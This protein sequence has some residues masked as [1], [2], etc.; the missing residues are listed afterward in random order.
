MSMQDSINNSGWQTVDEIVVPAHAQEPL[1]P[2]GMTLQKT[3]NVAGWQS[4]QVFKRDS[5]ARVREDS[6]VRVMNDSLAREQSSYGIVL[7][8]PYSQKIANQSPVKDITG[9]Y[10]LSWVFVILAVLFCAVCMKFKNNPKYIKALISDIKD[11]RIR[12]NMFDN[13]V[14]ETTFL[15]LLNLTWIFCVGIL[16]WKTL[17][18][19][20]AGSPF[21]SF[22][23]PD[24]P[25]EGIGLCSGI[26]LVYL[27]FMYVSYWIVGNVFS[28]STNTRLWVKGAWASIGMQSFLLF[29]ISLLALCYEGDARILLIIAAGVFVLGKILFIY[30]GFRIFFNQI[31]SWLLFL[32]YLCSLDIVPF[33]VSYV[34]AII[35][36][37]DWL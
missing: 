4:G 15:M 16:L 29:P 9:G 22:G 25:L 3:T 35:V 18:L 5:L 36:C 32:Y 24:R 20:A 30:K 14:K 26:A 33:I 8:A 10:G 21:G 27:V 34:A 31:P 11:I 7:E 37:A 13:T 6:V 17:R 1:L 23:I 2:K 19:T 12:H 28:D